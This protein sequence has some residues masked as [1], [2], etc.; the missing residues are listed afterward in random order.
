MHPGANGWAHL[1]EIEHPPLSSYGLLAILTDLRLKGMMRHT[2][3]VRKLICRVE[4]EMGV[5]KCG[6]FALALALGN[7][8]VSLIPFCE[9]LN[10]HLCSFYSTHFRLGGARFWEACEWR[11]D[12][13]SR[14]SRAG[15]GSSAEIP[16]ILREMT[17]LNHVKFTLETL[18]KIGGGG[19]S[20]LSIGLRPVE[21]STS[22]RL[23]PCS[24]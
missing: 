9:E 8:C 11:W 7:V 16:C 12:I 15:R 21:Q 20:A 17:D 1:S 13:T 22:S 5:K 14:I 6:C 23:L 2:C 24:P 19:S 3:L 10:C 18:F 4:L